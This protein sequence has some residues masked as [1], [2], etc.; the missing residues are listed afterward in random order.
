MLQCANRKSTE[1]HD[2]NG[3]KTF[4]SRIVI[5]CTAAQTS[6]ISHIHLQVIFGHART[7]LSFQDRTVPT[8]CVIISIARTHAVAARLKSSSLLCIQLANI[9]VNRTTFG[10]LRFVGC[11]LL[12]F[13]VPFRKACMVCHL[14]TN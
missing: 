13:L 11:K 9:K 6:K 1:Y 5:F 7:F 8:D 3:F 14:T 10:K 2:T 12:Q 4:L